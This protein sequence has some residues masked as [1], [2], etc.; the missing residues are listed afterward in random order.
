MHLTICK[1]NGSKIAFNNLQGN[2]DNL[3]EPKFTSL[4]S[5]GPLMPAAK[6]EAWSAPSQLSLT[7]VL[8]M[9]A[10]P[11]SLTNRIEP[12]KRKGDFEA[13]QSPAVSSAS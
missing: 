12:R 3:Q 10:A 6:S 2:F 7:L 1:S 5:T 8:S 9:C 13:H 11:A 4:R